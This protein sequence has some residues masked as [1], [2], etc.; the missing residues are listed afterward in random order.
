MDTSVFDDLREVVHA[1]DSIESQTW[2]RAAFDK[3]FNEVSDNPFE[4]IAHRES[5][6]ISRRE[7]YE[8]L[9]ISFNMHERTGLNM[10]QF[11]QLPAEEAERLVERYVKMAEE[12]SRRHEQEVRRQERL[13]QQTRPQQSR[14]PPNKR[15]Q[16]SF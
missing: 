7:R 12:E 11:F 1:K 15:S 16:Y 10:V 14:R 6:G 4:V 9:F 5:E 13:G 2:L 3:T 8:D